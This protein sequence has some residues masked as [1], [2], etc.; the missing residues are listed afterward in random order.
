MRPA[1]AR[2][3][4]SASASARSS[5]RATSSCSCST[6]RS[7]RRPVTSCS[8]CRVSRMSSCAARTRGPGPGATHAAA[9]AWIAL[10][11]RRPP[12]AS[13]RSGSSRKASSPLRCVRSACSA[14]SSASRTPDAARQSASTP[15]RSSAVSPGSPATCRAWSSPSAARRSPRATSRPSRGVRTAWSRRVPESQIGYQIRSAS[16][17]MSGRPACRS[18]TSRSLPGSSSRRPYPPT[19]TRAT[20]ASSPS[21]EA[22]Q[23]SVSAARRA[24]SAP[25]AAAR[26]PGMAWQPEPGRPAVRAPPGRVHRCA[27]ARQRPPGRTRPC[28]PRSGRSAPP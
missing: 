18:S 15:R 23:R 10:A 1:P 17:E 8:A 26:R 19:A 9:T 22:S 13:L 25:K 27:P 24:R 12:L 7:V 20:P 28:R 11:S 6:S 4:S 21:S 14:W 3:P 5:T 2:Q 16:T